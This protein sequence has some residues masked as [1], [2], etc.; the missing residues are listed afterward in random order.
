MC[1]N[2]LQNSLAEIQILHTLSSLFFLSL[3]LPFFLT[4][5]TGVLTGKTWSLSG[6]MTTL[7]SKGICKLVCNVRSCW[8]CLTHE[9][10]KI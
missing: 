7:Q 2:K 8:S 4:N 6:Q 9:V 10:F 1:Q 5:Q 3:S